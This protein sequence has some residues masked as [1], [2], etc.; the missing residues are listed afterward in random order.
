[1]TFR[2]VLLVLLSSATACLVL[3]CG[4]GIRD[5][6]RPGTG[7]AT[8]EELAAAYRRAHEQKD[9]GQLRP[10]DLTLTMLP[11]ALPMNGEYRSA[12]EGVFRLELEDVRVV[13]GPAN[14]P[15]EWDL[16]YLCRRPNGEPRVDMIGAK[17]KLVL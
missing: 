7:A 9:L 4:G 6:P 15:G 2:R 8:A 3:A 11:E 10:I 5:T 16:A 14:A 13:R 1:M 17:V 12:L